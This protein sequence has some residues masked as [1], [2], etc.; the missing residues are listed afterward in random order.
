MA[1]NDCKTPLL[2][3]R[4]GLRIVGEFYT[5]AIGDPP[6]PTV[7]LSHGF[8]DD[9]D[10]TRSVATGLAAQ[11]I[12]VC[13][14]DFIG[15]GWNIKSDG[16]MQHMSVLTEAADL[17]AV[18]GEVRKRPE[19]DANRLVLMGESQ[20]GF[21]STYVAAHHPEICALIAFYPAYILQEDAR[22]RVSAPGYKPGHSEIMGVRL[23]EI[24]DTDAL[25]FDIYDL[26]QGYEKPVLLIHGTADSIVPLSYSERAVRTFPNARLLTI[27]G[28]EHGFVGE[29]ERTA[30][31]ASAAFIREQEMTHI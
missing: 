31:E 26:M 2:C 25:A 16:D 9:M 18:L 14:F 3:T 5:P 4:D 29:E 1:E 15:G 30:V 27:P 12:A 6:F 22:R 13:I 28:A 10:G 21:V 17:E 19:V 24:Y 7:I 11:G 23:G 20:G 8:R